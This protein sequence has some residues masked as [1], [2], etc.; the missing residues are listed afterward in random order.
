MAP[1]IVS[2]EKSTALLNIKN[3]K[4]NYAVFNVTAINKQIKN[5]LK[6]PLQSLDI[7]ST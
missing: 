5:F 1:W 4:E 7:K 3:I 2:P 6:K